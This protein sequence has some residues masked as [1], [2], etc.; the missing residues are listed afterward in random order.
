MAEENRRKAISYQFAWI[1]SQAPVTQSMPSAIFSKHAKLFAG[2]IFSLLFAGGLGGCGRP[3]PG[4][5]IILITIDTLRSDHLGCYGYPLDTTPAIDRLANES[6]LFRNAITPRPKTAPSLASILTGLY[7]HTHGVRINWV[8][9]P[10]EFSTLPEL[11]RKKGYRTAAVVG[12]YVLKRKYSGLDQGFYMYDDRMSTRVF[13]RNLWEKTASEV[14]E[15][16][17]KWLEENRDHRFFL[18]IHYMDPHGPYTPPPEYEDFFVRSRRDQVFVDDIPRYQQLPWIPVRNGNS[19]AE[20]YRA[21]YD[22]EIRYCD[23]AIGRLLVRLDE[24]GLDEA[25]IVLTG[26]HGESLGEHDYYF[27]HGKYVYDQ[28]SR[29]P[30]I[31][32]IPGRTGPTEVLEQVNV[33]SIAPTIIDLAGGEAP[34]GMEASS[35]LPLLSGD[36]GGGEEFIF[37]ERKNDLKAIRTDRW[38]YIRNLL[39]G[40]EELYDLEKDPAETRNVA[41]DNAKICEEMGRRLGEWMNPNDLIPHQ[42]L[43]DMVIDPEERKALLS[44]GYL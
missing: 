27:E 3:V 23:D 34:A 14:N 38:K 18:W 41:G 12:N 4:Q 22:R 43:E 6:V 5:N 21:A 33:M 17:L 37:I 36:T 16:A 9:L 40:G 15:S 8:P 24:L 7:P 11:L 1:S 20:L 13:N 42:A 26:D 35:L 25:V 44:L 32:H 10:E 28:S 30:L 31:I 19:D 39:R 29:I 2:G